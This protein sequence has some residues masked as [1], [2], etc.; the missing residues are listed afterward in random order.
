MLFPICKNSESNDSF[1]SVCVGCNIFQKDNLGCL[2]T[3]DEKEIGKYYFTG[4][5][6]AGGE[7]AIF[8]FTNED[9]K[10]VKKNVAKFVEIHELDENDRLINIEHGTYDDYGIHPTP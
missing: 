10:Q 9:D 6:P 5:T 3:E 7:K 8:F 4:E 2:L 1:Y